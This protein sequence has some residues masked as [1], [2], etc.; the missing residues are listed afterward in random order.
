MTETRRFLI[1]LY[2]TAIG[3]PPLAWMCGEC[4][5]RVFLTGL[6]ARRHLWKTH[7]LVEQPRLVKK[8]YFMDMHN[9][10]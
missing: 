5:H 7:K 4:L 8:K 10:V 3:G 2:D 1:P 9:I 6:G